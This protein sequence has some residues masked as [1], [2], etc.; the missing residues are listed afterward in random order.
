M[1]GTR[2]HEGEL[3]SPV[4]SLGRYFERGGTTVLQA[5][6]EHSYFVHP[7]RVRQN[8]PLYPDRARYSRKHYPKLHKGDRAT[9][10]GREVR[11]DDNSAAQRAWAS[12]S[13]RPIERASGYGVRH[14]WGHPWDPDA[15]TAGWNL[16]YMP[17]WAGMLTER[18]HPHPELEIAVRQTAWDLYFRQDPVC[19]PPDFVADPGIDLDAILGGKPV[20]ILDGRTDPA[21]RPEL[22]SGVSCEEIDA[23]IRE[24]RKIT[25]QSWSNLLKAALSL[26]GKPHE[27]FGTPNVQATAQSVLRRIGRETGLDPAALERRLT[28]IRL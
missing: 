5:A 9:W 24:V 17:F 1:A 15:F 4:E 2:I 7:D 19:A 26:Q 20:L 13:G 11:L 10:Q 22:P 16:C 18:Q 6:F 3:V 25:R 21:N 28:A 8:T 14:V 12:Y 23:H 27:P